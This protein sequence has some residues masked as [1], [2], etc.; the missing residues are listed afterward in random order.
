M[1]LPLQG[2]DFTNTLTQGDALGYMLIGL[3]GRRL[4]DMDKNM[5]QAS[6]FD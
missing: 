1:L 6:Q 2:D 5:K 4:A 3:S